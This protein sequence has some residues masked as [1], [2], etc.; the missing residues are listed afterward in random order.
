[1]R[2]NSKFLLLQITQIASAKNSLRRILG[3]TSGTYESGNRI[4]T[5]KPEQKTAQD[6]RLSIPENYGGV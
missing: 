5:R 1:M 4:Q 2:N 6:C 3:F